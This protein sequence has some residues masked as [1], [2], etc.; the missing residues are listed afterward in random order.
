MTTAA[1]EPIATPDQSWI[2][3]MWG[4]APGTVRVPT[5]PR[6]RRVFVYENDG[7]GNTVQKLSHYAVEFK[8]EV[9][10]QPDAA[11][12]TDP[13]ATPNASEAYL[14]AAVANGITV[15]LEPYKKG[16]QP[17]MVA[18]RA[19]FGGR[20]YGIAGDNKP[21]VIARFVRSLNRIIFNELVKEPT[22]TSDDVNQPIPGMFRYQLRDIRPGKRVFVDALQFTESTLSTFCGMGGLSLTLNQKPD[23]ENWFEVSKDDGSTMKPV[24]QRG[25]YTDWLCVGLD[26]TRFVMHD[27]EFNAEYAPVPAPVG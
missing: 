27:A 12:T 7:S 15:M 21:G 16:S 25:K 26:G 19:W 20:E 4:L 10:E 22:A 8:F 11:P 5:K 24:M 18:A 3:I 17:G 9:D 13:P 14:S 1:D 6:I 23:S 2:E